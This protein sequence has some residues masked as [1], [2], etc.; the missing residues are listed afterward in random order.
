[1]PTAALPS[2]GVRAPSPV[3]PVSVVIPAKNAA[4]YI[5]ETIDSALMQ[6][7]VGEIIVV[8]DGSTDDTIA[9]V[10]SIR[11]PR[12]RLMTNKSSGV[13]AARN[14]GAQ[15]AAGVW[16]V[17]LDAD[18]RLRPGAV[19]TLLAA[20]RGAPR[21]VL[22][23]G[24]Y[25][26]IDSEGQQIGRRE[27]LKGRRKPSGDVLERLASGNFI[28]NGGI[29]LTRAEA[30][31]AVG[32]FDVT[33]RYCEDWHCWCRLAAIG[34]FE[35][36]PKLLLDYRL[37]TAN[38]MNATVRTPQDFLPAVTRVFDDGL[39]LAR[40]PQGAAARLR[41]AAEIHLVTYS[42][43]QAI[44]FGRYR[45]ALAYLGMVGRR[46]LKAMPRSAIRIVLA[47]LGI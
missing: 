19:A 25:N 39:I 33:L 31:R 21:A 44:R 2:T 42:A 20:A 22:V 13:S 16:L 45:Q 27:L 5:R 1:M 46:S 43:M 10:R 6:S 30:F 11:D 24:D 34:E 17:F 37:H 18:D 32:G 38:T 26:T 23:Y 9:I 4:A 8:D 35:F 41:Q 12:L 14:L 15:N 40:L 28:V 47:Y 29:V 7:S 36:V 3:G